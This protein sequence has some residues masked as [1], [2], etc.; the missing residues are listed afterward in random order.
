MSS[1]YTPIVDGVG[2]AF[3]WL[4]ESGVGS[5]VVYGAA[6]GA[7]NYLTEKSR[8]EHEEDL[9]NRKMRDKDDRYKASNVTQDEYAS[10]A[11]NLTGGL[12]TQGSLVSR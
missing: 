4:G 11:G 12:L 7:A 1:W 9:Y 8:Q 3:N 2:D 5:A 10:H 6:T